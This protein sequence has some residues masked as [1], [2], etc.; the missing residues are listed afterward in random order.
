MRRGWRFGRHGGIGVFRGCGLGGSVREPGWVSKED[1]LT[2]VAVA[3]N[4]QVSSLA[5][6]VER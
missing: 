5:V 6:G 4:D 3:D 1:E 2:V